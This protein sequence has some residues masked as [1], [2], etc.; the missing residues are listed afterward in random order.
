MVD[1]TRFDFCRFDNF[2]RFCM[3]TQD[4]VMDRDAEDPIDAEHV[5]QLQLACRLLVAEIDRHHDGL[6]L[7]NTWL[8]LLGRG[9]WQIVRRPNLR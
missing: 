6:A 4:E 8:S 9:H 2:I 1:R 5:D 7:V 3:Q